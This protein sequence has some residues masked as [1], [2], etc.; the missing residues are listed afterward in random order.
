MP[1]YDVI[2]LVVPVFVDP[3]NV[4]PLAVAVKLLVE[5]AIERLVEVKVDCGTKI[6]KGKYQSIIKENVQVQGQKARA[7]NKL[8][9]TNRFKDNSFLQKIEQFLVK[10]FACFL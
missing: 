7:K 5:D 2:V 4:V 1:F 8:L 3:P 9:R 10:Y 6:E